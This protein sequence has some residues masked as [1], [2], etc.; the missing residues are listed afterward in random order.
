MLLPIP[1]PP[2]YEHAQRGTGSKEVL[3]HP[4]KKLAALHS[5]CLCS[6]GSLCSPSTHLRL[7]TPWAALSSSLTPYFQA[8]PYLLL[9]PHVKR[10]QVLRGSGAGWGMPPPK[11]PRSCSPLQGTDSSSGMGSFGKFGMGAGRSLAPRPMVT[12]Q[13]SFGGQLGM[14][15]AAASQGKASRGGGRAGF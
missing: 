8:S 13:E 11:G 9:F 2:Q 10:C 5:A 4:A 12:P 1:W 7:Q 6:S 3:L 14:Q 15:L